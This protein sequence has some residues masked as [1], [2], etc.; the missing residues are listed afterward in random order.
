MDYRIII[1]GGKA[2]AG[3]KRVNHQGDFRSNVALGGTGEKVEI[4]AKFISIAE[5]AASILALDYC[6]VDVLIGPNDDEPILC[7]VNSNA[8]IEGIERVT[9][10]NVAKAYALHIQKEL[11]P[12]PPLHSRPLIF[13]FA[14]T[15]Q[16]QVIIFLSLSWLTVRIASSGESQ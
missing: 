2:I 3:M 11:A 1:V 7:E 12:P 16:A 15:P 6:G 10:V 13:K 4:P 8:F 9:G 14:L 5:K